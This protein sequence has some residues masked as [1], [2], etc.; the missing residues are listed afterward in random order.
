MISSPILINPPPGAR[1][2]DLHQDQPHDKTSDV[3]KKGNI[4]E[5]PSPNAEE[6]KEE[7][8]AQDK[9]RRKADELYK[10][11]DKEQGENPSSGKK[12][13][14]SPQD[15][16]H[17]PAGANHGN[18]RAGVGKHLGETGSETADQVEAEE[19]E[20]AQRILDVVP[21]DP[22]VEHVSEEVEEPAMEEHGRKNGEGQRH[23]REFVE[24][25]SSHDLIRDRA[26]FKNEVLTFDD[27]QRNLMKKNQ[28]IGQDEPDGNQGE[29]RSR[30]IVLEGKKQSSGLSS[31]NHG[32]YL[33]VRSFPEDCQGNSIR[34][35]RNGR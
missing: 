23:R 22:E 9:K 26:P 8:E 10:K 7:P 4:R 32:V 14:V 21:E 18:G 25:L 27:I 17:C 31:K 1:L 29:G 16:G 11:D 2:E 34:A 30:V 3:S 12:K 35:F 20:M 15:P 5:R 28:A 33:N 24:D 6:L 19:T 13:Q